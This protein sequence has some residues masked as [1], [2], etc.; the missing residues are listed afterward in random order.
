MLRI[1][2]IQ[3]K[4]ENQQEVVLVKLL[5]YHLIALEDYVCY[6]KQKKLKK[7][8]PNEKH[9]NKYKDHIIE[10]LNKKIGVLE[11]NQ[12]SVLTTKKGVVYVLQTDL[13][14]EDIYKI[15]KSKAFKNRIKTHNS[16]HV[17]N[18]KI[19][20]VFESNNID[21]VEGCLKLMLKQYQYKKRKEFYQV[22]L[23][24]IKKLLKGCEDLTLIHKNR[25]KKDVNNQLGGYFIYLHKD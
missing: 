25:N 4:K 10:I 8:E 15:G 20:L 1:L 7:L 12:K 21:A 9:L 6:Q 24:L 3:L 18:V 19:K 13:E 14:I 11:N 16:S 17:D 23:D 2:I 22:D 5:N